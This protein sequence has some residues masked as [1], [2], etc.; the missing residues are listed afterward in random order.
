MPNTKEKA[1]IN[2]HFTC[3]LTHIYENFKELY[4][5]KHTKYK[6]AAW[7]IQSLVLMTK[8]IRKRQWK[9]WLGCKRKIKEH[10]IKNKSKFLTW[11]LI[12]GLECTVQNILLSLNTLFK[13]H[14]KKIGRNFT[15][16]APKKG[17]TITTEITHL[18]TSVWEDDNFSR[19]VPKKKV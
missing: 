14:I 11:Y 16:P 13:L 8:L 9:T 10:H 7:K 6:L 4:F 1:P 17:E 15:K 5:R 19:Y 2:W 18:V 12:N 3:Q